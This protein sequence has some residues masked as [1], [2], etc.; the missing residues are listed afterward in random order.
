MITV[1]ISDHWSDGK[2]IHV[3]GTLTPSGNYVTGGD[4]L[5]FGLPLIK[6]NSAPTHVDADGLGA[7]S[8][9]PVLGTTINNGKLKFITST[10]GTELAAGAYPANALGDIIQFHGI[11]YK[12]I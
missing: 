3:V 4:S 10:T 8:Y 11:F 1:N 2:R 7:Y 5:N 12:F 9:A 6:S